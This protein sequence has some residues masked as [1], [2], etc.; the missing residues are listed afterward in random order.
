MTDHGAR[1][2]T[3][4]IIAFYCCD[5][6]TAA[7]EQEE[8]GMRLVNE[9]RV[10]MEITDGGNV[11][12][13]GKPLDDVIKEKTGYGRGTRIKGDL[14]IVWEAKPAVREETSPV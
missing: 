14:T 5:G 7:Q 3:D 9:E 11:V 2:W 12:I 1:T 4:G 8:H 10:L 13:D 6:P